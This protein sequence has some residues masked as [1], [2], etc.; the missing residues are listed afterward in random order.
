MVALKMINLPKWGKNEWRKSEINCLVS[1]HHSS[2][3]ELKDVIHCDC[4]HDIILLYHGICQTWPRISHRIQEGTWFMRAES[5]Q[6]SYMLAL[7]RCQV[8]SLPWDDSYRQRQKN[9]LLNEL[10]N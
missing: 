3:M 10:E 9:I 4:S 8:S 6:A 5:G 1:F 7:A 2:I